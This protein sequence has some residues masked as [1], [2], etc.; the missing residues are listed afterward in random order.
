MIQIMEKTKQQYCVSIADPKS[1]IMDYI[2]VDLIANQ[3]RHLYSVIFRL[4]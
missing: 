3:Q 2:Q 4:W 1:S